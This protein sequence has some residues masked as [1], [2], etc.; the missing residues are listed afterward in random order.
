LLA[1]ALAFD[2]GDRVVKPTSTVLIA[3]AR[4]SE[5][6]PLNLPGGK[7]QWQVTSKEMTMFLPAG[8]ADVEVWRVF[9]GTLHQ[10]RLP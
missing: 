10:L 2:C 4:P 7:T 6:R 3:S 5:G 1:L 9:T 8:T